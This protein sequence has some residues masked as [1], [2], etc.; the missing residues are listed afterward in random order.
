ML[1][2]RRASHFLYQ[3][4]NVEIERNQ[5]LNLAISVV[6]C[7]LISPNIYFQLLIF[8]SVQDLQAVI[9]FIKSRF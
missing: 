8:R 5:L 4:L 2:L 6:S 7:F 3:L 1:T 9:L